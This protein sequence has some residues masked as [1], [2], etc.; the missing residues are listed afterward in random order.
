M[1]RFYKQVD[2]ASQDRGWQVTL[3]GRGIKTQGGRPQVVPSRAMA[4]ALAH[5]WADQGE[6]IDPTLF[7]MRDQTDHAIDNIAT[8]PEEVID[9]LLSYAETDTLC[10][11]ADPDEALY[12]RQQQDWEPLVTAFEAREGVRL[13]RISGVM[14]RPQPAETMECLRT[15]LEAQDAFT[16]AGLQT[17]TSLA[18][19]L[20][21]GLCALE[22]DADLEQL[23]QL[24]NLEEEWQAELWGR[25]EQ[26]EA[27]NAKRRDAFISA[28]KWLRLLGN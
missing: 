25:D 21:I 10:Y 20:T 13:N 26:A 4:E 11:R 15:R 1:K 22:R 19:S 17:L 23:W 7:V 27:R 2:A 8:G 28:H 3:D 24:A 6:E 12:Q 16:L 18:A 5:E 9:K 14:H